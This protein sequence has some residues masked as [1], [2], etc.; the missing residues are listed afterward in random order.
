MIARLRTLAFNLVFWSGTVPIVLGTPIAALIGH[1][2]LRGLVRF[3][4]VYHD[5]C[6]RWLLGIASRI[7]GAPLPTPALYAGKHQSLYETIELVRLLHE[8]A[9]VM[10]RELAQI[11]VWGWA[12]QRYGMIVVDRAA[13]AGALRS[14]MRDAK[15]VL[16][17]GRSVIIFPEGTRVKPG[18]QP[19]LKSGLA[20]LYKI[21][22][23]PLVPIAIDSGLIWPKRGAKRPGRI[24]FRFGEPLPPGLPRPEVEARA[25]SGI[26]ALD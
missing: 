25:H 9:I 16:A 17:E 21:L 11:P 15:A 8:P 20:G 6:A 22:G 7:E 26:N 2:P 23:L 1:R 13:S 18:E 19:P 4:T 12:A 10:K 24:T 3:W 5:W 14:M